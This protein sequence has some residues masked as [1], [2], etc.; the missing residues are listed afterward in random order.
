MSHQQKRGHVSALRLR[1]HNIYRTV[2][3]MQHGPQVNND[4]AECELPNCFRQTSEQSE[5]IM[6]HDRQVLICWTLKNTMMAGILS[7][8]V[9]AFA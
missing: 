7:I 3:G 8:T 4:W 9:W 5:N 6:V 1:H 2:Q